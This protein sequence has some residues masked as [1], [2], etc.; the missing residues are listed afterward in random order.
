MDPAI[1]KVDDKPMSIWYSPHWEKFG[2]QR[3]H[4]L[5]N[6]ILAIETALRNHEICHVKTRSPPNNSEHEF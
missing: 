2:N 4:Y 6:E 3:L 1:V 5:I